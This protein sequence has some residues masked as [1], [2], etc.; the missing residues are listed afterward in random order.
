MKVR[1]ISKE[2]DNF[3]DKG[4]FHFRQYKTAKFLGLQIEKVPKTLEILLRKWIAFTAGKSDFLFFNFYGKEFTSSGLTKVLN[5]IFGKKISVNQL[6]HIYITDKSAPLMEE[7]QRTADE[8]GH[9]TA[10]AKLYVKKSE[11]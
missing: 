5:T 11:K 10:Q 9:S 6:R 3:Y 8:M 1:A 4:A 2:K 7:L